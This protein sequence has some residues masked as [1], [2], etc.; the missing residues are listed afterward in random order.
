M[1]NLKILVTQCTDCI[2]SNEEYRKAIIP[3]KNKLASIIERCGDGNGERRKN[4][5]IAQLIA[6]QISQNR[7]TKYCLGKSM[8]NMEKECAAKANA[9][10]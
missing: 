5:Y 3:A 4:Y 6:E 1:N 7:M 9:P 10:S 8:L 2:F